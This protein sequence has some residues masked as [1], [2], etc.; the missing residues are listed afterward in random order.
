M[1]RHMEAP[2]DN[3]AMSGDVLVQCGRKIYYC[4]DGSALIGLRNGKGGRIHISSV[5]LLR[6][7][8]SDDEG[9]NIT[10]QVLHEGESEDGADSYLEFLDC[11]N[12]RLVV[13]VTDGNNIVSDYQVFVTAVRRRRV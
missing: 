1:K 10:D 8:G 3:I 11:G 4:N 7:G 9:Y 12:Y 13:N 6:D 2:A 5:Y